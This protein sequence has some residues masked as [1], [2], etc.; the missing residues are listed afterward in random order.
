VHIADGYLHNSEVAP[1]LASSWK[2]S[3]ILDQKDVQE[4]I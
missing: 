4:Q 1:E 2:L 3:R